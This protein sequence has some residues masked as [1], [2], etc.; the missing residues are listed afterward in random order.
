MRGE[1]FDLDVRIAAS[2]AAPAEE[3]SD[4]VIVFVERAIGVEA[5]REVCRPFNAGATAFPLIAVLGEDP[6][7]SADVDELLAAGVSVQLG[8]GSPGLAARVRFLKDAL[9]R[10]FITVT[11]VRAREERHRT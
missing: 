9:R 5:I 6:M 4:Y 3:P 10:R 2:D 7:T 8:G 1:G 11:N